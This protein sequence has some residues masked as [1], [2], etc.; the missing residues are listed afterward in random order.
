VNHFL[1]Q[2]VLKSESFFKAGCS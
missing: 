1:K 2:V